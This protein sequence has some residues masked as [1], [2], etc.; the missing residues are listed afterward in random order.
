MA[1]RLNE[2]TIRTDNTEE[3]MEKIGQLWQDIMSGKLPILFDS[4]HNF[5]QE[6]RLVSRYSNYETDEN[7]DYDLSILGVTAEF[8][9]QMDRKV[10]GGNYKK[11]DVSDESGNVTQCTK[12]AWEKVW[13]EQKDGEIKRTFTKDYECSILPECAEDGKA[14]CCL[15]I[16]VKK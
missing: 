6:I 15:Y 1:Y 16:A 4:D 13:K 8:F 7:G 14:Y 2:V 9:S 10:S 11:Y 3:G 5:L 12:K